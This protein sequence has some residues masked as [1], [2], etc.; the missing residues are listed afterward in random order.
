LAFGSRDWRRCRRKADAAE[1][2]GK[3]NA[4]LVRSYHRIGCRLVLSADEGVF[5]YLSPVGPVE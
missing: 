5:K 1:R 2:H 4:D 3:Q